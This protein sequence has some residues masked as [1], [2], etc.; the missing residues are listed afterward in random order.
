ML[1][2]EQSKYQYFWYIAMA[3][4]ITIVKIPFRLKNGKGFENIPV[5]GQ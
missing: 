2:S 1:S 5:F 3:V 4:P